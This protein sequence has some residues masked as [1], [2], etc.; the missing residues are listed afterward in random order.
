MKLIGNYLSKRM[1]STFESGVKFIAKG[2]K[3]RQNLNKNF[4]VIHVLCVGIVDRNI[5]KKV[6]QYSGINYHLTGVDSL[7]AFQYRVIDFWT[8]NKS[9]GK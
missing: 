8:I 5:D 3:D 7:L 6:R 9:F 4:A 1:E 2:V